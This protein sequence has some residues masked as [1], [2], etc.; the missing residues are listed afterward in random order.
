MTVFIIRRLMQSVLVVFVMSF[1]V[2]SGVNLVGDPVEMMV[3][4]EADQAERERVI[5]AMGLDKPWYVQYGLF[6]GKAVQGELGKSFTYGE[7]SLGIIVQR[8]PATFELALAALL[9][10]IVIGIPL[11]VFA[12]LKPG[13]RTSKVIMAGSILGFSLP[14]FWVGLMFIM[15]FAVMLGWLPSTGHTGCTTWPAQNLRPL[16]RVGAVKVEVA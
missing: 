12:G 6:V 4:D 7:E 11:G 15:V 14:T 16:A 10:A 8:M 2:F 9:M 1:L 5:K 13:A 3:N